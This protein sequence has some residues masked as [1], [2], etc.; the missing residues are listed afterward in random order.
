MT[1][2]VIITGM[3]RS[4]TSLLA[5]MLQRSG[6]HLGDRLLRPGPSN[7]RGYFEDLDFLEFHD[8]VL[9]SL[10]TT[11]YLEVEPQ[12]DIAPHHRERAEKLIAARAAQ[13]AWGW[14]D[15]RTVFFLDL[16]HEI[17]PDARFIF[18][19]RRPAEVVDSLRRRRDIQF[20][21]RY[22]GAA[23]L[24]RIGVPRFR[25]RLALRLWRLYNDRI[26]S[27]VDR[28]ADRCRVLRVDALARTVTPLVE[29]LCVEGIPLRQDVD[30]AAIV[31]PGLMIATARSSI[32]RLCRL[33]RCATA[34]MERLDGLATRSE[35]RS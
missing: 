8:D 5:S 10:G 35:T 6:L 1:P 20:Q 19:Y 34:L 18:V 31:E 9:A 26:T 22:P 28:H 24:E 21:R 16:W 12:G 15:P 13:P 2:P 30:F 25:A 32:E 33:D 27:F 23:R 14:K 4:G 7:R 3:H 29:E 11:F 17:V